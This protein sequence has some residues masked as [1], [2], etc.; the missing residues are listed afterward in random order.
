M[1]YACL[2]S[3]KEVYT[4]C[5]VAEST[6]ICAGFLAGALFRSTRGPKAAAIAG[7]VGTVAASLLVAGRQ[8]LDKNL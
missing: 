8:Y 7:G 5:H 3:F 2:S 1:L 4:G 6:C